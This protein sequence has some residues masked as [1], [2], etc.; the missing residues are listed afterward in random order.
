M[1]EWYDFE[2][3][4]CPA[5][6]EVDGAAREELLSAGCPECGAGVAPSAF[7]PRAD[8]PQMLD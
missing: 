4:N 7:E 8:A 1:T 6:F 3:A 2:C 5:A